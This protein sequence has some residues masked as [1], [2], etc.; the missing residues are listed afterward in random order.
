MVVLPAALVFAVAAA[1]L[2][3]QDPGVN[4]VLGNMGAPRY[5]L[6]GLVGGPALG[7]MGAWWSAR[8]SAPAS[9]GIGLLLL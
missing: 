8:R 5:F 1:L 6:A 7:A 4:Q 2:K 3:G 9:V